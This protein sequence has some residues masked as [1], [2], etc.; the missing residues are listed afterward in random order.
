MANG[1]KYDFG[2]GFARLT[3]LLEDVLEPASEGQ[4]PGLKQADHIRLVNE[5]ENGLGKARSKQKEIKTAL[6]R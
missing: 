6:K 1:T 4:A 2:E 5:I 3:C